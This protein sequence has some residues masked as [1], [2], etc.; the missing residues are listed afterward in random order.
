M[1]NSQYRTEEGI[2]KGWRNLFHMLN[3]HMPQGVHLMNPERIPFFTGYPDATLF[4]W[5]QYFEGLIQLYLDWPT[6]YATNAIRIFLDRQD[7]AGYIGRAVPD[8]WPGDMVKPF[9]AQL[10]LAAFHKDGHLEWLRGEPYRRMKLYVE[11]WF[12]AKDPRGAGLSVWANAGHTGMDNQHDRAGRRKENFCEGID[13]NAYLVREAEAM[14]LLAGTLGETADA[15]HF[16]EMS[17]GRA[18]T[19]RREL[20]HEEDGFFYDRDARDGSWLRIKHVGAFAALWAGIATEAQAKRLVKE[21][22]LNEKEFHRP[23]PVPALAANEPGYFAGFDADDHPRCCSWRAHTWIPTNYYTVHGLRRYGFHD[24]A[25]HIVER[26]WEMFL[27]H[28]FYEYYV[29]E[30]GLGTGIRP[31]RGWSSLAMFMPI[32]AKWALDPTRLS[33]ENDATARMREIVKELM[34]GKETLKRG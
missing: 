26:T 1:H 29:T 2:L 25:N 8:R 7:A 32:E 31:F 5:D 27:T 24:A 10:A 3:Y 33:S 11:H 34:Y 12:H 14:S 19:V 20:W 4:D 6:V 18:E 30:N 13:L 23:W 15:V 17:Q 22:L 21:H 28:P 9:L 16:R